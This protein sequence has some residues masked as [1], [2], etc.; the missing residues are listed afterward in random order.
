MQA[1]VVCEP[2]MH[3]DNCPHLQAQV[4]MPLPTRNVVSAQ[5]DHTGVLVAG[6][7]LRII[8]IHRDSHGHTWIQCEV[9]LTRSERYYFWAWIRS[10]MQEG[11]DD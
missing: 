7:L 2:R 1:I 3:D 9:L 4:A 8:Q 5:V 11:N 6:F 10:E